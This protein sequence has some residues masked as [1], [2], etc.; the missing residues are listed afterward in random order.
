MRKP[1]NLFSIHSV[2]QYKDF[3]GFTIMTI[4]I[5]PWQMSLPFF[6]L[7]IA[8]KPMLWDNLIRLDHVQMEY[9]NLKI[10]VT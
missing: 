3:L 2:I 5:K 7:N 9:M 10:S 8:S 1:K 6:I 4:I